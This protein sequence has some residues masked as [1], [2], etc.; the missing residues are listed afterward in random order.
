MN[1]VIPFL[2]ENAAAVW[3]VLGLA[4][5]IAETLGAA[6]FLIS[7][8]L[9]AFVAALLALALGSDFPLLYQTVVF[10]IIGVTLIPPCRR[11]FRRLTRKVADINDY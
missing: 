10:S 3:G 6:G 11:V 1:A 7:F 8:A 5:L 4:L 2:E 9:G